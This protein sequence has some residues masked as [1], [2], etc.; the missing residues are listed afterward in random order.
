[1]SIAEKIVCEVYRPCGE[2]TVKHS[3]TF[4]KKRYDDRRN[5]PVSAFTYNT[6]KYADVKEVTSYTIN[7]EDYL[8]FE[9]NYFD[10]SQEPVR[11]LMSYPH[12]FK[13]KNMLKRA[14][15]W[16]YTDEFSDVFMYFH[17]DPQP[18]INPE[19]KLEEGA[20]GLVGGAAIKVV[21]NIIFIENEY[22]EG[23]TMYFNSEAC[24]INLTIDQLESLTDFMLSFR[25]YEA[26]RLLFA[27]QQLISPLDVDSKSAGFKS[28]N[29]VSSFSN[30][31][32][33][34]RKRTP[35]VNMDIEI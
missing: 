2:L 26:S 18:R 32:A 8:I 22:Y 29:N 4:G 1:M 13:V 15:K 24:S 5:G 6:N 9:R 3:V 21:P 19:I 25:L 27:S 23:V 34:T 28:S 17:D 7:T 16:F 14:L 11:I 31:S 33:T 10:K 20:Y 30:V 12:I 35:K